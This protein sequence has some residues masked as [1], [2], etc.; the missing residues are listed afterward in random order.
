MTNECSRYDKAVKSTIAHQWAA[1]E[2]WRRPATVSMA[3]HEAS[4][5]NNPD[6]APGS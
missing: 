2:A 3:R 5:E 6:W 4:V 1:A